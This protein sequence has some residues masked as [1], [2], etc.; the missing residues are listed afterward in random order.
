MK[1]C[2]LNTKPGDFDLSEN[3]VI[4]FLTKKNK[5]VF[6]KRGLV[7]NTYFEKS[8]AER[9]NDE[10]GIWHPRQIDRFDSDLIQ[11][12]RDF[13]DKANTIFSNLEIVEVDDS[14]PFEIRTEDGKETIHY[15]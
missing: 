13:R 8:Q 10:D 15:K 12:V 6:V 7:E 5:K 1:T 4:A 2:V 14:R 3:A 9:K 11:V